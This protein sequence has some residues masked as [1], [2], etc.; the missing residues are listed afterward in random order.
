MSKNSNSK[1]QRTQK[2]PALKAGLNM[3][4]RRK[5][6]YGY[7]N[8]HKKTEGGKLVFGAL[9]IL[10]QLT[11]RSFVEAQ[12]WKNI[13]TV[14][15]I[16]SVLPAANAASPFLAS[17]RYRTPEEEFYKKAESYEKKS[18][19]LY[20]LIITSRELVMPIDAAAVH[21]TGVF[22]FSPKKKLDT[23]KAEA[24]LNEMF[25]GH[26]LDLKV[27]I[28]LDEK[29]F[30]RRLDS[31]KPEEEYEDDGQLDYAVTLLK[32]LSM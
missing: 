23:A 10:A 1:N 9:I 30:F 4:R 31:L 21:P 24:F 3:S 29:A 17:F 15:A 16:L 20:D 12:A 32:N 26:K 7:R 19:V 27:K 28:L 22:A 5:G 18:R 13:L 2:A 25:T 8:Y 14:M 6:Q 11:A